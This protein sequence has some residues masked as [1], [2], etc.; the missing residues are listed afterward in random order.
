MQT[1]RVLFLPCE[2]ESLPIRLPGVVLKHRERFVF[3][4]NPAVQI[5]LDRRHQRKLPTT[6]RFYIFFSDTVHA[7]RTKH[8]G[9]PQIENLG[10]YDFSL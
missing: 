10:L 6:C 8:I 2:R 7:G 9:G 3:T 1:A 4:F 5:I